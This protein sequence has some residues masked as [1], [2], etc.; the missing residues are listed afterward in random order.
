MVSD[1]SGGVES[2]E[3]DELRVEITYVMEDEKEAG[4]LP[5][6][7]GLGQRSPSTRGV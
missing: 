7:S 2:F 6:L 4:S 3:L 5:A 1:E